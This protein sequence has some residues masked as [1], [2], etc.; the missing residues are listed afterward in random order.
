MRSLSE[1]PSCVGAG[2]LPAR[3]SLTKALTPTWM[4]HTLHANRFQQG[5]VD[6]QLQTLHRTTQYMD[7]QMG[8]SQAAGRLCNKMNSEICVIVKLWPCTI[9]PALHLQPISAAA[10]KQASSFLN[11]SSIGRTTFTGSVPVRSGSLEI[12]K[13]QVNRPRRLG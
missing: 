5:I 9:C 8:A 2:T 6:D 4:G 7:T 10:H 1:G 12:I 11:A 3:H 13:L